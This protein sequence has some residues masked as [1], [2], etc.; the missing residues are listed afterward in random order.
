MTA[1]DKNRALD[2]NEAEW[3]EMS[4]SA[5]HLTDAQLTDL[6][7]RLRERRDRAQRLIR[8]RTRQA[9]REGQ[10]NVDAGAREKK[11]QLA[12]AIERAVEEQKRRRGSTSATRNLKAA[13]ARKAEETHDGIPEN[14]T[15]NTGPA[16]TPNEGIAPSG[17]LHAEGM[18]AAI[19]RSTGDR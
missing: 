9:N 4:R 3:V 10:A 15:A 5:S 11:A 12:E 14:R 16:D 17:A 8:T 2:R 1:A 7:R 6:L 19:M 13:V 18:R